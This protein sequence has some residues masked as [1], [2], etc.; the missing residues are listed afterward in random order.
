MVFSRRCR[1]IDVLGRASAHSD[2]K[3]GIGT[4]R[5]SYTETMNRIG[6]LGHMIS[7]QQRALIKSRNL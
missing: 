6:S 7:S 4:C 1:H 5:Q 2:E 3:I